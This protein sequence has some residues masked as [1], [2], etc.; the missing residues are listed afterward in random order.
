MSIAPDTTILDK[1]RIVRLLGQGGMARVWLAEETGFG[2][3]QVAIKEPLPA[4]DN[5]EEIQRRFTQELTIY[6]ALEAAHAP[7]LVRVITVE[8][9]AGQ[10]LLVMEYLP[11]QDLAALIQ[12]HQQGLPVERAIA[13][14]GQVLAALRVA[15]DH[16]WEIVHRDIKPA[17]IL[18]DGNGVARLADFGLAQLAGA[19]QRSQV[20]GQPH[21]GTPAYMA[22]E[23]VG[24]TLALTP[25]AD[26]YAVGT[27]LFE[28]LTGKRYNRMP[29][30]TA[31]RSLR[32]DIPSW[33]DAAVAKALQPEPYARYETAG[34]MAAALEAG[35]PRS[36]GNKKSQPLE[37]KAAPVV[38]AVAAQKRVLRVAVDGTQEYTSIQ[39]AI[40][41]AEPGATIEV[42]PGR[43]NGRLKLGREV[44]LAGIG[45]PNRVILEDAYVEVSSEKGS[46]KNLTLSL[47]ATGYGRSGAVLWINA[48]ELQL[49]ACVINGPLDAT[50][51]RVGSNARLTIRRCQ[52]RA[53]GGIVIEDNGYALIQ[54][55]RIES[56]GRA[57]IRTAIEIGAGAQPVIAGN[58]IIAEAESAMGI[59]IKRNGFGAI[60]H[61]RISSSRGIVVSGGD[62]DVR[63]NLFYGGT[64]IELWKRA[65]GRYVCNYLGGAYRSWDV[66]DDS[67]PF[68][69]GNLRISFE[70]LAKSIGVVGAIIGTS[71]AVFV[72]CTTVLGWDTPY[73]FLGGAVALFASGF[74]MFLS[75]LYASIQDG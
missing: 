16:P 27:V 7:N 40:D 57:S 62:P 37:V 9:C 51:V 26:V 75:L 50:A 18:F 64:G 13:I 20:Q 35:K 3:R 31:A 24:G 33:L 48:G 68:R 1:Y 45:G 6:A 59:K 47:D 10:P 15:H 11:G 54:N 67:K 73:A 19:S 46:I 52:I 58:V 44:H 43:Y 2:R 5:S 36:A 60:H 61:N 56:T 22:P 25:A 4:G 41:A 74:I 32:S 66:S 23:Q 70:V 65:A 21:P 17:N 55:N 39:E 8:Q 12:Q 71:T 38:R 63:W 30:G 34:V 49:D 28:M 53:G 72:F 69:F 14:A 29:P 42:Y